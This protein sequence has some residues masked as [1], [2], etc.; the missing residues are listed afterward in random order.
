MKPN[1]ETWILTESVSHMSQLW[2]WVLNPNGL[3]PW[4]PKSQQ[5]TSTRTCKKQWRQ[6]TLGKHLF[7]F[8]FWF[9]I[10]FIRALP[11]TILILVFRTMEMFFPEVGDFW[12][13]RRQSKQWHKCKVSQSSHHEMIDQGA[14]CPD[15]EGMIK[16]KQL[17]CRFD[18]QVTDLLTSIS[19]WPKQELVIK[20]QRTESRKFII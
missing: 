19:R 20:L 13:G 18:P 12:E 7:L 6:R 1:L 17:V 15:V 8:V 2:K 9:V 5:S 4:E 14:R 10:L 3:S 16:G 11:H